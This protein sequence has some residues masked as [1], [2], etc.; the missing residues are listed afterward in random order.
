MTS[1]SKR[2]P[3]PGQNG[4]PRNEIASLERPEHGVQGYGVQGEPRRII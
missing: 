4:K 3:G 2:Q 1:V